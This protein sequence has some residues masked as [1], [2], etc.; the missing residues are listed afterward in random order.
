MRFR[1]LWT[2]CRCSGIGPGRPP[3]ELRYAPAYEG[4]DERSTDNDAADDAAN[5]RTDVWTRSGG[6]AGYSLIQFDSYY[7]GW[8]ILTTF[9]FVNAE[10]IRGTEGN[11]HQA[12]IHTS[13][14][15]Y[16]A[17]KLVNSSKWLSPRGR[18]AA[19][20]YI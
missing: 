3:P 4:V 15:V 7:A 20:P 11:A 5:D 2:R 10:E 18:R 19:V 9:E 1:R 16:Y 8:K 13:V 12:R 6:D 14:V 17:G